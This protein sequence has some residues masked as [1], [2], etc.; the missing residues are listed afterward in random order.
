MK[1]DT[2]TIEK[3]RAVI[4]RYESN[5]GAISETSTQSTN[6]RSGCIWS[7]IG[8]CDNTCSGSCKWSRNH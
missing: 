8:S 6:C 3:L 2:N 1:I 5:N 4:S 7:C